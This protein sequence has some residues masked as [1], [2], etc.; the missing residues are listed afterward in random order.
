MSDIQINYFRMS[1]HVVQ[2][3]WSNPKGFGVIR[4]IK[5]GKRIILDDEHM[6]KIFVKQLLCEL[7]DRA[8]VRE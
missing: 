2:I 1:R 7:I 8:E 5:E 4:L 3:E 6:G